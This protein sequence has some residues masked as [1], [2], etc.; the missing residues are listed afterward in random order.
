MKLSEWANVAEIGTAFAV[1]VSIVY[2]GLEIR[3]NTAA[4]RA[5]THQAMIDY[6]REQSEILVTDA[7]MAALVEM[8][9]ADPSSLTPRDRSRF[10]EFTTWGRGLSGVGSTT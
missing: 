3:Q 2:V 5:S 7:N 4:V 9:E 8:G 6:G 1:V 10:F